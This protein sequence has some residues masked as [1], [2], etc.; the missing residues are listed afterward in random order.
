MKDKK[1]KDSIV[2]HIVCGVIYIALWYVVRIFNG[3]GDPALKA[4]VASMNDFAAGNDIHLEQFIGPLTG[5]SNRPMTGVNGVVSQFQVMVSVIL[6][7]VNRK[8]GVIGAYIWNAFSAVS[9]IVMCISSNST[10][11]LPGV[12]IAIVTAIIVTIIDVF[13]KRMDKMHEE[14]NASYV[15]AI[16]NNRIIQEKDEVLSY[17]AYYDRLTKLPNRQL[18]TENIEERVKDT[19]EFT[20]IYFGLD[21][22]RSINDNYGHA[23]GD[24]LLVKYAENIEEFCGE[25]VFISRINGNDF[26]IIISTT[27]RQQ[28]VDFAN[29]L[30]N[31]INKPV[32]LRGDVFRMTASMGIAS[33]PTDVRSADDV[34]RCA[35]SAMFTAK[36][37][38]K[39][40][41]AF[42]SKNTF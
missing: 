28:I 4:V 13:L 29:N 2:V 5:L 36:L 38:G 25:D 3:H 35:E 9:S 14:L 7:L 37:N 10:A 39:A 24:E 6:V 21:N 18:F 17:L 15:Q 1:G 22:F 41:F 30:Q 31:T 42:Y 33:F 19:E 12:F 27:N 40:Q 23:V 32:N 16:E 34:F 8:T 26:G 20:V 11:P